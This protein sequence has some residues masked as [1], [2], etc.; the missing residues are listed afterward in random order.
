[1]W[2]KNQYSMA[3]K[4]ETMQI[5]N[6]SND[7]KL[8]PNTQS[9][10]EKVE[11]IFNCYL[12]SGFA[13]LILGERG[14]GKSRLIEKHEGSRTVKEANCASFPDDIMAESDLFGYIKGAFTGATTDKAGLIK[15]AENGILFLD[16]IHNL[17]KQV[18][19]KLMT[20]FR[21]NE[22]NELSI[23][24]VGSADSE[25][26]KDVRLVFAS[27]RSIEQLRKSLLPDFYDR[28][29]Q[30]VIELPPLRETTEYFELNWET[31]WKELKFP[32]PAP[33][34]AGLM[35]WLKKLKLWGNFRD[36]QKIAMYYHVFQCFDK[37][38]RSLIG[39][40]TPLAFAKA[41][42]QKY[43][44]SESNES[45]SN[46][47]ELF[48]QGKTSKEIEAAFHSFLEEW[49]IKH[50]GSRKQAAEK[51]DVTE[52]TLNNWRNNK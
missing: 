18:Q 22:N 25:K 27:N 2:H 24:R 14:T 12:E 32:S 51:L 10:A 3:K 23:R 17:S 20:A 9:P 49:A 29:V 15:E 6:K 38:T 44:S 37:D 40:N 42:F 46:E 35:S 8:H 31:V 5:T 19:A 36:L 33:K 7:S 34:E 41:Q 1:M 43:G 21:T 13:I 39:H 45:E 26:V 30:H 11:R 28:I 47:K 4:N 48:L 50:Y 52:K 16:E